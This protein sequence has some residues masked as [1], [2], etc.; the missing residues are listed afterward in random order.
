MHT[1]RAYNWF[2]VNFQ[3]KIL[4][5]GEWGMELKFNEK[6]ATQSAAFLLNLAGGELNYMVLIKDLY[7]TDRKAL[8]DWGQTV[9]NDEFYSMKH[10]PV[11]SNVL[12]LINEPMPDQTSYW[13]DFISPP[14]NYKVKLKKDPGTDQLSKAE[15]KLLSNIFEKYRDYQSHPFQFVDK[16]HSELPEWERLEH[17]RSPIS[18]RSILLAVHKSPDEIDEIENDL[19]S[20]C[21]VH[22][23]FGVD[24]V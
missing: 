16:V 20:S 19:K 4:K 11:L 22:S 7:L 14:S 21:F 2:V 24:E 15:E 17:G 3:T 5:V 8:E 1:P 10:G 23:M 12:N 13:N 18:I 9:T 6:K